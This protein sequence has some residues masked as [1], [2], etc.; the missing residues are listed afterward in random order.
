MDCDRF[1]DSIYDYIEGRLGKE[2]QLSF[3]QHLQTCEECRSS[4]ELIKMSE[5]V[6]SHE[7]SLPPDYFIVEKVMSRIRRN[8]TKEEGNIIRLLRPALATL[9]VAAAI[10]AG[11]IIG[12]IPKDHSVLQAPPLELT[13]INDIEIE[14]IDVLSTD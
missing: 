5:K 3:E 13:L 9:S 7:K 10:F 8:E 14:S 6:I 12:N 1:K 11:V 4:V 2:D